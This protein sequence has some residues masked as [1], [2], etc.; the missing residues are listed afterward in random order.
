MAPAISAIILAAGESKRMSR[1]K[2]LMPWGRSTILEQTTDN[3][4]KSEANEVIVVLGHRA[5]EMADLLA[6][7]PVI[8]VKNPA[9]REGMSTSIAAG[10]SSISE[11]T[12]GVMF[13]LADQPSVD[14]QTINHLMRA[15]NAC[16][17]GI[18]VPV[19]HGKRGHPVIFSIRYKDELLK[20]TGDIGGREI[21]KRHSSDVLEL[22]VDCEGI[23]TDLDTV[24]NYNLER[25]KL[26]KE[27]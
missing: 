5:E 27:I 11:K 19:Y 18:A 1:P 17:K 3:F 16:H 25:C 22:A 15:S 21:I 6:N 2:Q 26:G 10:L 8:I 24:D 7:R 13:A 20:L 14:Y 4:L 12:K 23:C 9:Y